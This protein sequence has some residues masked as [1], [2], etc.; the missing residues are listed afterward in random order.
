MKKLI[1]FF[2]VFVS[3]CFCSGCGETSTPPELSYSFYYCAETVSYQSPNGI[4]TPESREITN[5][6]LPLESVLKMYM[7][8]PIM[9][10]FR[11]P[12]PAG[13]VIEEIKIDASSVSILVSSHF[14]RL[15]GIQ[16]TV[17]GACLSSTVFSL[18]DAE[19][20]T[21]STQNEESVDALQLHFTRENMLLM[22]ELTTNQIED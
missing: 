11:S 2:L 16:L 19:T 20:V 9:E 15:S 18:C 21:I 4:I 5:P 1:A 22:D 10:G 17:A 3:L 14:A 8:G 13:T 6:N 12:Y 7:Q